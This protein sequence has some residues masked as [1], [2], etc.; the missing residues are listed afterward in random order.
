MH[1][2]TSTPP[3][4]ELNSEG[5][6]NRLDTVQSR[7]QTALQKADRPAD[8]V[9]LIGASKKQSVETLAWF[10]ERG[11]ANLGENYL[12][13]SLDKQRELA[14]FDIT[15]HFIGAI[16]SNKTAQIAQQFDWV[17]SVDRPKIARRLAEQFEATAERP[18]L[19]IL[20]QL[21]LEGEQS[22]AGLA[23]DDIMSTLEILADHPNIN[24]RG[25]MLIPAP[26]DNESAQRRVFSQA[27]ELL[28][29]S[30]AAAG[31]R[32]DTLSMGM[33]NDLEAAI[34]EGSTMV[35]IGTDLFG[36]RP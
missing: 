26:Q 7:I 31:L 2:R 4:T 24:C 19:N 14:G 27:R 10:A 9:T 8:E 29:S 23:A 22:K 5:L 11:V 34:Y 35:R 1:S 28:E 13:E 25:F 36:P 15:W 16:Q 17:H 3:N 18:K 12:Q 21:N 33:S 6:K 30:N 20:L 32:M